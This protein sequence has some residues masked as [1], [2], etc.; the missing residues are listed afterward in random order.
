V[1]EALA[2]ER[3][4]AAAAEGDLVTARLVA[5]GAAP[6]AAQHQQA[7]ADRQDRGLRG[8]N[9][10]EGRRRGNHRL[11]GRRRRGVRRLDGDLRLLL[12]ELLDVDVRRLDEQ[13]DA[14]H[15]AAR[16]DGV[17]PPLSEPHAHLQVLPLHER[18]HVLGHVGAV[19]L[20]VVVALVALDDPPPSAKRCVMMCGASSPESS[21]CTWKT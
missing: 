8:R 13:G 2:G 9:R 7:E 11:G 1:A 18:A 5:L 20:G 14:P 6:E 21:V 17:E 15:L 10:G 16:D 19:D 3:D 4:L 12:G